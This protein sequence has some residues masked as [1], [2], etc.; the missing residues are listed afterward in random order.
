MLIALST[1][2]VADSQLYESGGLPKRV[3]SLDYCADQYV[4]EFVPRANILALSP[5]ATKSFLIIARVPK[6]PQILPHSE[7]VLA[8]EPDLVVRSYAGGSMASSF[9][10]PLTLPRWIYHMSAVY[11]MCQP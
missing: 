10:K 6:V 2:A 3:V 4:L 5:D 11:Q 1:S 7:R 9:F 8:L